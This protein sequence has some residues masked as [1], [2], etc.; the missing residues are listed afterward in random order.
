MTPHR[1]RA[2]V[3]I[4]LVACL[5]GGHGAAGAVQGRHVYPTD[6]IQDALDAAATDPVNKTVYVHAGTYRPVAKGQAL[7]W[8]NARHDGITLEAVGEV[9]LTAA[10]PEIADSKAPSYPAVVNHVVYFGDGI[11]R[12]TV[13]RG[14][15]I[16]GANNFTTGSGEKSPIESDDIR[17]TTFF[18]TDG[19]GIK[20]YA[21][22]Y[23]TIEDVEVHGNYASPCGGGVSVEHLGQAQESVLFRNCIFRNNR[24]Q[25]TGSAL[26]LLHGSA[27]TIENCLFV[28]N[29][30]NMGVDVVGL[31]TGGEYRPE[32]G[33][34][35]MTVFPGS[36]ATV[37]R[38]TVTGN[39]NGVDDSGTGS[40][41]V[42]S[43]FWKNSLAGGI[44]PAERYE[45]DLDQG[46]GVRG[47]FIHGV[48]NDLKG[49]V[50][51]DVNTFDPPD[52]RFDARFV[53]QAPEYGKVGYRPRATTARAPR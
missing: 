1:R 21:R 52:P 14:F 17:K 10:N 2:F 27:A 45:L 42:D 47:S 8:F 6:R 22:S 23:P 20:I 44:S 32:H 5:R 46:A 40:T 28:G 11:S 51:H 37:S 35:A 48:V 39:W 36:K 25:T 38:T 4:V 50:N 3:L 26:D 29:V 9:I 53:P 41:Y 33:S 7:I 18:Y 34:G 15:K 43:I 19:G 24:T 12:K 49:T 30:A 13:L 31:L 16:T